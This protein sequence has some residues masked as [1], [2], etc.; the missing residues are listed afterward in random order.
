MVDNPQRVI[1]II[2]DDPGWHGR[3]LMDE[4]QRRSFQP[5]FVRLQDCHFDIG[6]TRPYLKLADLKHYPHGV[7]IRGIPGGNLETVVYYLDI[8]HALQAV[9]VPVVN[10]VRAIEKSV[11]KGMTSFLLAQGGVPTPK[12]IFS[13]D[14]HYVREKLRE[15]F[16]RGEKYVIKPLFGSQ[17][18]GLQR[19]DQ[20]SDFVDYAALHGVLYIQEF[21]DAGHAVGVDFRAFVVAGRVIASMRRTGVDWIS[22]VAHGAQVEAVR[23][24]APVEALAVDAVRVLDMEYAGVDLIEDRNGKFWVTEVNSVPAWKG[25]QQ[26]TEISIASRI[27]DDFLQ[28]CDQASLRK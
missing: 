4:L 24:P 22:N 3:Q 17:G 21:V 2:T 23:L 20:I 18:K 13:S 12:T 10:N 7:F 27:V 11:D 16:S 5:S 15:G 19:C 6:D 8:L 14:L 28:R 9:G 25:L 26:T 1:A